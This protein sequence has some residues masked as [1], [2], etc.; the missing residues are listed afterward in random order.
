MKQCITKPTFFLIN[1]ITKGCYLRICCRSFCL[2]SVSKSLSISSDDLLYYVFSVYIKSK[3][4]NLL[5]PGQGNG[6][7]YHQ[8]NK[9]LLSWSNALPLHV[10]CLSVLSFRVYRTLSLERSHFIITITTWGL[11]SPVYTG[12]FQRMNWFSGAQ[13]VVLE[14]KCFDSQTLLVTF[15]TTLFSQEGEPST[16]W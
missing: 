6:Q 15:R 10:T 13:L 9:G 4:H 2:Q 16:G 11:L 14:F 7:K 12:Y 1:V 3:K 8:I 5:G